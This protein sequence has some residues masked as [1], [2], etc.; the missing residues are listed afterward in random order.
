MRQTLAAFFKSGQQRFT[1]A[2]D[3]ASRRRRKQKDGLATPE[4]ALE[5]R[6]LLAAQVISSDAPTKS[7]APGEAIDIPVM[8]QTLNDSGIPAALASNQISFNLHYDSSQLTFD[9]VR[10]VFSEGLLVSPDTSRAETDGAVVG[11]DGEHHQQN[12][13]QQDGAEEL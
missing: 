7:L 10:N 6:L 4:A 13:E 2:G 5:Q 11:D 9:S 3:T 12:V 1:L 8:Y